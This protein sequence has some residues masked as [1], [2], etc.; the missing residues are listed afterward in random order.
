MQIRPLT[1]IPPASASILRKRLYTAALWGFVLESVLLVM[2][3]VLTAG[4]L[5]DLPPRPIL[6]PVISLLVLFLLVLTL[7]FLRTVL[8]ETDSWKDK[9]HFTIIGSLW[10]F[11]TIAQGL[12]MHALKGI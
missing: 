8:P 12:M 9:K 4:K 5:F 3:D 10:V 7:E 6:L 11:M 2:A 1:T